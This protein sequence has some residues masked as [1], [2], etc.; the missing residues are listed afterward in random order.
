M[1]TLL[2]VAHGSR[3]PTSNDAVKTLTDNLRSH[4]AESE[5]AAIDYAFL[6]LTAPKIPEVIDSL[7]Q[8]G[9]SSVVVLPYFLA[10]GTHVVND[11]PKLI[12]DARRQYPGVTFTVTPHLG[13]VDG[14]AKLILASAG[15][16]V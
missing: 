12:D 6:E 4:L 7:I 2:L 8:Q 1:K 10:P 11:L 15:A 5:F 14:M 9:A 16:S 13:A 3:L